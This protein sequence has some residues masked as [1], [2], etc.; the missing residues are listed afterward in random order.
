MAQSG[1]GDFENVEEESNYNN[2][3][4][5]MGEEY[6]GEPFN[7]S[8]NCE[9]YEETGEEGDENYQPATKR[10]RGDFRDKGAG[11][12]ARNGPRDSGSRFHGHGFAH[13][14]NG[15][16]TF[17]ATSP[18]DS[19]QFGGATRTGSRF[20]NA[21]H[22]DNEQQNFDELTRSAIPPLMSQIPGASVPPHMMMNDGYQG[23]HPLSGSMS[24]QPA[25][26]VIPE[27]DPTEAHTSPPNAVIPPTGFQHTIGQ[28]PSDNPSI[29][30]GTTPT[31]NG[32]DVST[33]NGQRFA[34]MAPGTGTSPMAV[35]AQPKP[36]SESVNLDDANAEIWVETKTAE[37]KSYYYNAKTRDTTWTK[38]EGDNIK[39]ILQEQIEAMA[40][41]SGVAA[42]QMKVD[43]AEEAQGQDP[44]A[45]AAMQQSMMPHMMQPGGQMPPPNTM[46]PPPGMMP[47]FGAPP[48][49][50]PPPFGMPPPGFPPT[51]FPGGFQPPGPWGFPQG[52]PMQSPMMPPNMMTPQQQMPGMP[53][54]PISMMPSNEME[55]KAL[56]QIDPEIL[57]RASEW[58]E[59]RAPDGRPYFYNAKGGESVWEKPQALKDFEAAKMA[60]MHANSVLEKQ[61]MEAAMNAAAAA[62]AAAANP[63]D[64]K[65]FDRKRRD[66]SESEDDKRDDNSSDDDKGGKK[67]KENAHKDSSVN[68]TD[69]KKDDDKVVQK[70]QDKSK[71]VSSTPVPGTPWCVVWTGDGRVFF[72]NPSARASVW[73]R[74][75]DLVGRSDVTKM[76]SNPPPVVLALK[77]ENQENSEDGSASNKTRSDT[78]SHE[79][80]RNSTS[81]DTREE[82]KVTQGPSLSTD[83]QQINVGKEAAMEAEVRAARERAV[84]P[85]E[86]RI[87]SF[88][89]M[90]VE[91][92]VSAFSTWEKELHKIVFDP[93]YLLLT[94]KERKQVFEKY[95]K[96]R[97]EEER[98]EKRNRMKQRKEDYKKLMEEA[99]LHGKSSFSDF[100]SKYGK[101]ERFRNIEK[102]RERES[103]FNEFILDV[104]KREKEEKNHKKEQIRREFLDLLREHS[105][106]DRHSRW[107]DVKKKLDHDSRYKMVD[108]STLR[109]DYFRDYI[110][111]LK[112]ERR[113]REREKERR[114]RDRDRDQESDPELAHASDVEKDREAEK[115]ARVEASI[116][117]R[118][119]EV[120]RTLAVHLRDR[121]NEREQHKHDEAVLHFN[122]LLADLVR[123]SEL[124]WREAKRQLRK[125]HRWDAAELLDRDEKEKLFN[126][127]IEQLTKKKRE[128]F[129]ELLDETTEI[130]LNSSWKEV[131]RLIRD[132]PRYSKFSSSERKCEKEFKEYIKDKLVT[133]KSDFRELL[134][135]TKLITHKTYSV[136]KENEN[137]LKE[138][139][140]ILKNDKRYLMLDHIPEERKDLLIAYL[141]DLE[142]RG[143]PP[144]PTASE[145]SRRIIK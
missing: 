55:D 45:V 120:Q 67:R 42:H 22:W 17:N 9:V 33:N 16:G 31:Q 141:E 77:K 99:N 85:L 86:T 129:R 101:D 83:K 119:K 6:S 133:I 75:E 59:H 12:G 21:G 108:S 14:T 145:P 25:V 88:R 100:S 111:I 90:L 32:N 29:I 81:N 115:A 8:N 57:A 138:I 139:E 54:M 61:Q 13:G 118:E 20:H 125:D 135:E 82:P 130:N 140:D 127:H 122:A 113:H 70:V 56:Q 52:M 80:E 40:A 143:P 7:E 123:N 36:E 132:D 27:N 39:V 126:E 107:S 97:A 131:R 35:A 18:N 106:I 112:D 24:Q 58:T 62:A 124:S 121:D 114:E 26:N 53:G 66:D 128:K 63:M 137:H 102:M 79:A 37:G 110:R 4:F 28:P 43:G 105:E 116:R 93:R 69:K 92:E 109:E 91:K 15:P 44:A 104:R 89:E 46:Q 98:Q 60:I 103:L 50:G 23:G 117:E 136:V 72:Y 96:E 71:P 48:F 94:S 142:K 19:G 30:P 49:G 144:P 76:V 10:G 41:A 34:V 74:P 68:D 2:A 87:N 73:E 84:V 38:P 95:V 51:A 134:Q 5:G 3:N 78:G 11:T 65:R 1:G 64:S 47:P